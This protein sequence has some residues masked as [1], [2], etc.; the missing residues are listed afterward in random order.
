MQSSSTR[1]K[2]NKRDDDNY[3]SRVDV[4]KSTQ[5][6]NRFD[7]ARKSNVNDT[8]DELEDYPDM[9]AKK[10]QMKQ[11]RAS[12]QKAKSQILEAK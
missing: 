7:K 1:Y 6:M 9:T 10:D 8:D 11:M 12:S 4:N 3:N 5:R 2:S